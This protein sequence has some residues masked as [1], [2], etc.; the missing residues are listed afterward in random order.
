MPS[1][2][3]VAVRWPWIFYLCWAVLVM[4]WTTAEA[5]A[6]YEDYATIAITHPYLI[7]DRAALRVLLRIENRTGTNLTLLNIAGPSNQRARLMAR[8]DKQ[9]YLDIQS[10]LLPPEE[11]A[12]LDSSHFL[13]VFENWI[14][15]EQPAMVRLSLEF[16]G[17]KPLSIEAKIVNKV[18]MDEIPD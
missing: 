1:H 3:Q 18:P 16:A 15:F 6:H 4:V 10:I 8:V 7:K 9:R 2:I 11:E 13:A 5:Q 17:L 14:G 12:I